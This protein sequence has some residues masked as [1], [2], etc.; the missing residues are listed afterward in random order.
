MQKQ[1]RSTISTGAVKMQAA[2][3]TSNTTERLRDS[4]RQ[5]KA[6][7]Q[8]NSQGDSVFEMP[9]TGWIKGGVCSYCLEDLESEYPNPDE[10]KTR[11]VDS[12]LPYRMC[13]KRKK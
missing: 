4:P 13:P 5:R 1:E 7:P 10:F 6:K 3:P 2:S 12:K 9:L 11:H 8:K